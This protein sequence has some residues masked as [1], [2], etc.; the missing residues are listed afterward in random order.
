MAR[1]LRSTARSRC[2][3]R[4][5]SREAAHL[6]EPLAAN[7][8]SRRLGARF[9]RRLRLDSESAEMFESV[10]TSADLIGSRTRQRKIG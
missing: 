5:P 10:G 8:R 6:A 3:A 1:R 4:P 9:V 7:A 2:H